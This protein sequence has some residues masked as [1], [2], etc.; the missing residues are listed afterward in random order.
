MNKPAAWLLPSLV[1]AIL[2]VPPAA[3]A[4]VRIGVKAGGSVARP[5]G[6][7]SGDPGATLKSRSGFTG[8]FFLALDYG[9]CVSVQWEALYAMKGTVY[10]PSGDS[11]TQTLTADYLEVPLLLKLRLPAAVFEPFVF[12]GPTVGFKLRETLRTDGQETTPAASILKDSDYGAIFGAGLN[13]GPNFMFDLRY[14]HGLQMVVSPAEAEIPAE[15]RNG[16]WSM[17]F[18]IVF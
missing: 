6:L 7:Q 2:I 9:R 10:R 3:R 4:D 14:S 12:A 16:V 17:S 1:A 15:F 5:T 11:V 13:L 18:G 8:G